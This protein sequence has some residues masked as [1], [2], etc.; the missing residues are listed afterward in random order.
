MRTIETLKSRNRRIFLSSQARKIGQPPSK[1]LLW[2][3]RREKQR[4]EGEKIAMH[5]QFFLSLA[6]VASATFTGNL[7]FGSPS[8]THPSLGIHVRKAAKRTDASPAW[9][10]EVL[11]FTHGLERP[12]RE[13][14]YLVDARG[15]KGRQRREQR[16]GD[17][18]GT[19]F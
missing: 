10:A 7:N 15:A 13:Q 8:R 6:V 18:D 19:A 14:C 16:D 5:F 3:D 4:E 9:S 1:H 12:T 17:R 2:E 11:N